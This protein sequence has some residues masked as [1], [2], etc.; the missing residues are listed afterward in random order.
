[1]VHKAEA[2][3]ENGHVEIRV[4]GLWKPSS[5]EEIHRLLEEGWLIHWNPRNG[6]ITLSEIKY[7]CGQY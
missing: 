3:T 1:M 7:L 2:R 5:R 4:N 6:P